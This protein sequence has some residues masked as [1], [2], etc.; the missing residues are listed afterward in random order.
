MNMKLKVELGESYNS[1]RQKARVTTESWVIENC[2]CPFCGG[3]LKSFKNNNKC[4]DFYCGKCNDS[5]ELKSKK[6]KFSKTING[7][8]YKTTLEKVRSNENPNWLLLE[9]DGLNVTGFVL[10]PKYF[11][12]DEMIIPR[13]PLG[14]NARRAGWQGCK[15]DLEKLPSF[16]K[17]SL[18][19]DCRVTEGKI[20]NYRLKQAECFKNS[21]IKEKGWKLEILSYVDSLSDNVFTYN[22]MKSFFPVLKESHPNNNHIDKKVS[23]VLQQ[24]R[25]LGF[26]RFIDNDGLY[27][28]LF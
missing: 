23:Q 24:L 26:I 6:G 5:F 27:M 4:S 1:S 9:H 17:I 22:Q 11:I 3:E 21:N 16:G 15:L 14:Q 12:Y 13:K 19:K 18:I 8:E 25:D 28:K 10:I 20:V 7:S 2:K